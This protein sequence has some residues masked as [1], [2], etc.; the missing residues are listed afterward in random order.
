[1]LT[2]YLSLIKESRA[3]KLTHSDPA[4]EARLHAKSTQE[5]VLQEAPHAH[6][7]GAWYIELVLY[8]F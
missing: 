1:M 5:P 6:R 7:T 3:R 4:Q 2:V 8:A